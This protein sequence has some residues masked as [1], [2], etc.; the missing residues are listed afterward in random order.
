VLASAAAGS[1]LE[2]G[3]AVHSLGCFAFHSLE[4]FCFAL[5][6]LLFFQAAIRCLT[7][8][9]A[10]VP[11]AQMSPTVHEQLRGDLSLSC[12]LGPTAERLCS[13]VVFQAI[14]LASSENTLSMSLAQSIPNTVCDR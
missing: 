4:C 3:G 8:V 12:P 2:F 10:L 9:S 5:P 1:V 6:L 13:R 11:M 14:S 7:S